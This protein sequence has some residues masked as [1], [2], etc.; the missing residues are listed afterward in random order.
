[1]YQREFNLSNGGILKIDDSAWE[2]ISNYIQR[3]SD[4]KE[5]GGILLGRFIKNSKHIIV[6][7]VTVPMIGDKRTRYSFK[8]GEKMHQ[9]IIDKE[10]VNSNGTCNYIGEWHTHPENYPSPSDVDKSDW[11]RKLKE[12]NFSTR[13]LYF[14]I[15][16]IKELCIWEGDRRTTKLKKL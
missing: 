6:D 8:R 15:L 13:Y 5:A 11:K 1:M 16:G 12:G 10:W 9:R 4:A 7:K 2:R 3:Q 14:G